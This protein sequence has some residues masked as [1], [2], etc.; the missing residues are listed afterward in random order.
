[1]RNFRPVFLVA[2]LVTGM[3]G[4]LAQPRQGPAGTP[5]H[6]HGRCRE[7]PPDTTRAGKTER[8]SWLRTLLGK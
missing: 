1:M 2:T 4:A 8:R 6:G 7:D 5:G 3:G